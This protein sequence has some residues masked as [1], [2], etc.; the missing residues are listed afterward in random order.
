MSA[1]VGFDSNGGKC[2][3]FALPAEILPP[4]YRELGIL[5]VISYASSCYKSDS[6]GP[7]ASMFRIILK[8][9][10]MVGAELNYRLTKGYKK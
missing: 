7:V 5:P 3:F 1:G 2:A 10:T 6:F 8:C 9:A 4:R